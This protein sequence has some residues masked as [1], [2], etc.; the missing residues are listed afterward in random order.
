MMQFEALG[1]QRMETVGLGFVEHHKGM[2]RDLNSGICC[3]TS[4]SDT[5]YKVFYIDG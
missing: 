3:Q 2:F 5:W 4:L 1:A